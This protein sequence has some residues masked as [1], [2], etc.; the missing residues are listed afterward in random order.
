MLSTFF[1]SIPYTYLEHVRGA[2]DYEGRLTNIQNKW[3]AYTRKLTKE[4]QD[5]LLIV[6]LIRCSSMCMCVP[7]NHPPQATVLLS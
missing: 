7:F 1:F 3:E 5:F 4:Y 2:G 6:S